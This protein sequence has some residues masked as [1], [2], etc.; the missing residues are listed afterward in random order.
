MLEEKLVVI[1]QQAFS[2][3]YSKQFFFLSSF[4]YKT[5]KREREKRENKIL[6]ILTTYDKNRKI[7]VNN[8]FTNIIS[9]AWII[10]CKTRLYAEKRGTVF[11]SSSFFTR[12]ENIKW[13]KKTIYLG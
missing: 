9:L 13:E 12:K 4:I 8:R 10:V 11:Y 1:M 6:I 3:F 5:Y 7:H 2:G